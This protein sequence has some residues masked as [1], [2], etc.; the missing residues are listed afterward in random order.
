MFRLPPE[1]FVFARRL[2][3]EVEIKDEDFRWK[4]KHWGTNNFLVV[5]DEFITVKFLQPNESIRSDRDVEADI[6]A[7]SKSSSSLPTTW[8]RV[9][10][11]HA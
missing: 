3:V 10:I 7:T 11:Q 5:I 9:A 8:Q 2:P 6:N 4:S 1:V